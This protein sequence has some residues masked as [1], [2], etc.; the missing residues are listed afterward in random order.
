MLLPDPSMPST[1]KS[2]PGNPGWSSLLIVTTPSLWPAFHVQA[3]VNLLPQTLH[4]SLC[5]RLAVPGGPEGIAPLGGTQARKPFRDPPDV[6]RAHAALEAS[7]PASPRDSETAPHRR[8]R[9]R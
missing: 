7:A 2:C 5:I 3:V 9:T 6:G 8:G 4:V 1:M